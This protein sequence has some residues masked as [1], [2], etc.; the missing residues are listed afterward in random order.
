MGSK[1][2]D[3]YPLVVDRLVQV[4]PPGF[5]FYLSNMEIVVFKAPADSVVGV[6]VGK[7][8]VAHGPT[9][10]AIRTEQ[11]VKMELDESYYGEAIKVFAAPIYDDDQPDLLLGAFAISLSRDS[12]FTLRRLANTYQ[13]GMSEMEV[14]VRR[15]A[16]DSHDIKVNNQELLKRIQA[17]QLSLNN[18]GILCAGPTGD[19][20]ALNDLMKSINQD[21]SQIT[22]DSQNIVQRSEEQVRWMQMLSNR[23]KELSGML[24]DLNRIAH[25]I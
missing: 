16:L 19:N 23:I 9:G 22:E 14:A 3:S 17:I 10:T 25:D 4:L 6:H 20:P 11:N 21:L 5:T 12:A 7:P 24:G 1:F 2:W 8:Y 15:M 18:V 13:V